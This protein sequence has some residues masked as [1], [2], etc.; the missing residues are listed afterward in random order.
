MSEEE[1]EIPSVKVT[2]LGGM[3][4]GKTC[5]IKRYSE[6]T[7]DENPPS[8]HGGSY[9]EKF[10][11]ID[12]KDY[13]INLWDTAGQEKFRALGKHFYKDA[14]II[15]LVYDITKKETFKEIKD[16]WYP[17]VKEN[18]EK[19][20]VLG[21]VGNKSDLFEE[22]EVK[23]DDA[24]NYAQEINANYFLVSAKNGDNID[25]MFETLMRKYLGGDFIKK[26]EEEK[27]QRGATTKLDSNKNKG[28]KKKKK[29]C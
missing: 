12:Q 8:T 26:I 7:F 24:R 6:N 22:E 1:K 3:T 16:V 9:S 28:N 19:Y 17:N 18:G 15:I 23:E 29:C 13:Q 21:L 11:N 5:I 10:I 25:N 20:K 4:V 27:I 14:Y 2:L